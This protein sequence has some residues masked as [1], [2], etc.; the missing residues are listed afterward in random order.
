M[1][2]LL[3]AERWPPV[4]FARFCQE[5]ST[6]PAYPGYRSIHSSHIPS[7]S[8]QI[9]RIVCPS[10]TARYE[11][12]DGMLARTR[13]VRC[14]RCG[15]EWVQD[16]IPSTRDEVGRDEPGRDKAGEAAANGPPAPPEPMQNAAPD[17]GTDPM[18]A[19]LPPLR[20][21]AE[22]PRPAVEPASPPVAVSHPPRP[23]E[24]GTGARLT[25]AWIASI[26]LLGA[27]AFAAYKYRAEIQLAWPPSSRLFRLLGN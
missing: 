1:D 6:S 11:I 27:L 22:Q 3:R 8:R 15:R 7:E 23:A 25:L 10:C 21:S 13:T 19:P 9:M 16:P 24:H 18:Q 12:A 4:P 5:M 2:I 14:S 26:L 17:L 20:P